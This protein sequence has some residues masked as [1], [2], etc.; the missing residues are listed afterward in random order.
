M[1]HGWEACARGFGRGA[2]LV[3]SASLLFSSGCILSTGKAPAPAGPGGA[4]VSPSG[5]GGGGAAPAISY[6]AWSLAQGVY[7]TG[8]GINLSPANA[9][10]P[11]LSWTISPAFPTGTGV[12]FDSATGVISGTVTA[13]S[14]IAAPYLITASNG[15]GSSSTSL[16]IGFSNPANANFASVSTILAGNG[17]GSCISCH[18]GGGTSPDLTSNANYAGL[19]GIVSAGSPLTSPLLVY[20]LPKYT[21]LQGSGLMPQG[22]AP[23]NPTQ[24]QA[25]QDWIMAGAK[26]TQS[27]TPPA[28]MI[29][30]PTA[31]AIAGRIQRALGPA[32]LAPTSPNFSR[33]LANVESSLPLVTDPALASGLDKV[34]MLVFAACS[35]LAAPAI[36][37]VY[38]VDTTKAPATQAGSLATAGVKMVNDLI[39]GIA[40]NADVITAQANAGVPTA[41]AIFTNLVTQ[42]LSAGDSTAEA[43]V[44]VCLAANTFGVEMVGY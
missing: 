37:S 14:A 13:T 29:T 21:G 35:D 44:A 3:A 34:P 20:T 41:Q 36:L 27:V 19:S 23:L 2:A 32:G 9:G 39:G 4:Q 17:T 40:T 7:S 5:S 22:G 18:Y 43:F 26:I 24:L 25:I 6:P 12:S 11:A 33:E 1:G 42:E 16:I 38:G 10:G 30:V 28:Q 31:D 15:A 8:T